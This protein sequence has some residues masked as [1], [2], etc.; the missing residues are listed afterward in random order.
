MSKWSNSATGVNA[1]ELIRIALWTGR[2]LR[3]FPAC[4]EANTAMSD[5]SDDQHQQLAARRE[6]MKM[7]FDIFKHLTTLSSGS[8]L[9]LVTL[10]GKAG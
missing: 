8:I 6:G 5:K 2:A 3:A 4:R 1:G 10:L 7:F 9:L